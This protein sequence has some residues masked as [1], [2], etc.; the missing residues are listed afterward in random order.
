M[1]TLEKV[2]PFT[3]WFR[4]YN[5]Q[6]L[7][8]DLISGITVALVLIPQSM[9]YAQLAGL[10]AYYGLYAAFL[11][12][13]VASLFGSS[14]QLA[15]GPVAVVSLMTA[16]ALE[17]LATAG[18]P[19]F[20][21]YAILLA[22]LVGAFQF[23]LGVARLGLVI[24][25]LSHT[26]VNGFT[27]AAAIIIATSQLSKIFGVYVDKAPHHYQ[28]IWRV[29][30]AAFHYTHLPTLGMAALAFTI[31]YGLRRI[32][33]RIPNVLVAVVV[34]TLLAWAVGFEDNRQVKL[35]DIEPARVRGQIQQYNQLLAQRTHIEKT[36]RELGR[37]VQDLLDHSVA[38]ESVCSSC[39]S[40][41]NLQ[42]QA[43]GP[44]IRSSEADVLLLH[45]SSGLLDLRLQE[46]KQ[47]IGRLRAE[48][49]GL[50]FQATRGADER[51]TFLPADQV[52]PGRERLSG[53]WRLKIGNGQLGEQ[54]TMLGGGA[55]VARVPPGLPALR[56]P[57]LDWS[58]I[59][60]LFAM[61]MIISLLGFM[62]AISIAKAI[63]ARTHQR[64][65]PNQ[66][67]IGQG[68]ANMVGCLGQSYAVSGSFSRSAVNFQAGAQTGL[69]NVFSSVVVVLVLL[70]CTPLLYYLPQAVL[71]AIIM[72]AVI[73]LVNVSGFVHA[74]RASRFDGLTGVVSFIATLAFAPH[75]EYGIFLGVSL[76]L[77][78]YL[79]RTM[80][81]HVAELSLHP[82][83][84]LRDARRFGL[85]Q[86]RHIAAIRFDG[87]LNFANAT[88]LEDEVLKVIADMPEL[89]HVLIAAHGINEIDA[90]G[91]EMLSLLVDR[92]RDAGYQVSFSGLKEQ[93]IDTLKRT[94]LYEKIG[95]QNMYPTQLQ[96]VAN[97]Y[98]RAH[99]NSDEKN[100][101][102]E[103]MRP[104]VA[105]LSLHPDGSLRDAR[106]HSLAL[107]RHIAAVRFDSPLILST[108]RYLEDKLHQRV[109]EM[110]ELRHVLIA[111]HS[112]NDI[113]DYGIESLRQL[114]E[115]LRTRSI[116][117]S[118]SGFKEDVYD[119]LQLAGLIDFIGPRNIYPTQLKAVAA[120]HE[121][122]HRDSHEE[123]CP[124]L[125]VV[126]AD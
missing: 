95:E 12:P 94:H 105:D 53:T 69:S 31:I 39:H 64:L 42:P 5:S 37:Q 19:Q 96:A 56:L 21:Q 102:L 60:R 77:G 86:C 58:A 91:E 36:R 100:C 44:A 65:D 28:T 4:G 87:P 120:I 123:H 85:S 84:S 122:A 23:F 67:L 97:I 32:D 15:T 52:P 41:R 7:R 55:V 22:L 78:A 81:P 51:L 80:R 62:E 57:F 66:E 40:H 24:N 9:A 27:N 126:A 43:T 14:N 2:L 48:L 63:A 92:M 3:R 115:W 72:Q 98:A 121:S 68:I 76:S 118:F 110:P 106:R 45:H 29:V 74:W 109:A 90:S 104:R 61:A 112:I 107:C 88:Y 89:R 70:F 103:A 93:V 1:I 119:K 33:R 101:P 114:V 11:P 50:L 124:L 111:A 79:L 38:V 83:G 116:K 13:M 125:E 16:A 59:S 18:S 46:L 17:P 30:L 54:L 26:V 34:T 82:D 117:V 113:D 99:L 71:A 47:E 75:L 8:A 25:F 73:G 6:A 108:A 20:I 49:R 10:P 35:A